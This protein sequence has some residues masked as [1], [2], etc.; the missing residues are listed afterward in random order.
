V[1]QFLTQDDPDMS[2]T[3]LLAADHQNS[4][5][6]ELAGGRSNAIAY[7]AYGQQCAPQ[8]IA[9]HLGFNG[10]LCERHIGWYLLG[11]GYRAYNPTL[12]R[13]HSPD[14]WSPFGRGGLN[15]YVYC[16]GDPRNFTDPTGH[17]LNPLKLIKKSTKPL[18]AADSN[19]SLNQLIPKTAKKESSTPRKAISQTIPALTRESIIETH[20]QSASHTPTLG[21]MGEVTSGHFIDYWPSRKTPP[22]IPSKQTRLVPRLNDGGGQVEIGSDVVWRSEPYQFPPG[23][24]PKPPS[25]KIPNGATREYSVKYDVRGNPRQ[26]SVQKMTIAEMAI[27]FRNATK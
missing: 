18:A 13:F 4:I 2:R 27:A 1:D 11:N 16:G 15:A 10:E 25:R 3:L 7:S 12:M 9:T 26:S 19:S 8:A 21:P 22:Q 23:Y 20:V 24:A 5:V 17:M 14:S 6:A